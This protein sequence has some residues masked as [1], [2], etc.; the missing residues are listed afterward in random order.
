MQ[1]RGLISVQEASKGVDHITAIAWD[2]PE[3]KDF[4]ARKPVV[5]SSTEVGDRSSPCDAQVYYIFHCFRLLSHLVTWLQRKST[6]SNKL[7]YQFSYQ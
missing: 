1:E 2:H 5:E 3:L 4:K 7:E 6:R